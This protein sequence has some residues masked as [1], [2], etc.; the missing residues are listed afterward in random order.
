MVTLTASESILKDHYL[1]QRIYPT[2]TD[3]TTPIANYAKIH[4]K[5]AAILHSNEEYGVAN[6]DVFKKIFGS[7]DRIITTIEN[8][9]PSDATVIRDIV[10]KITNSNPDTIFVAGFG[11]AYLEHGNRMKTNRGFDSS[12]C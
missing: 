4:F 12:T 11:P 8:Y 10:M 1:V 5:S 7:D 2:S 6:R 3:M 9:N